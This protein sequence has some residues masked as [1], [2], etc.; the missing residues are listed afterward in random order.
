M[1]SRD[2]KS[3]RREEK[4][5]I[6]KRKSPKKEDP[7]ARKGKKVAKHYV[8]PMICGSG[9]RKVGSL[10]R[11][12]RSHVVRWEMSKKCTPL[13]REA[14]FQV[15]IYKAPH[16]HATFGRWSIVLRGRRKG[17]CTL[18]KMSKTWGFCSMSKNNG[19]R[20]AFEEDLQRC[21][22]RGRR[23][24]RD[25]F[26]RAVRRSGR[27]FPERDCILEHQICRFA[28]MI[29]RDRC[30]TSY[31]LASLFR[32]RRSNYFRQV[33]WKNRKMH[34]YEAVSSA[35]NFPYLKKV[36]QNCFAFDVVK[37]KNFPKVR[38]SLRIALLWMLSNSK[39]EEVSQ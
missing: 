2:G 15:K 10:K 27:W 22:F 18:S 12:V 19:K 35:L 23:S 7:G 1:K 20:G 25:M 5:K 24:A 37:F 39:I 29:L 34:W 28:K 36:S 16:V 17:L 31:D 11:R 4:K 32:G 13:W 26:L 33:E 3:Q 38:K 21:I 8:F 14:R 30:S 6:K 9:D